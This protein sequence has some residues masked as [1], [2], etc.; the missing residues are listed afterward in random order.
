MAAAATTTQ[1][2]HSLVVQTT[3]SLIGL[4][5]FTALAGMNDELGAVLVVF[6]WGILLGWF[7]LHVDTF[8]G[9]VGKI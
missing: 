6:M 5:A 7:L 3:V 8:K 1:P 2:G 4:I 9:W